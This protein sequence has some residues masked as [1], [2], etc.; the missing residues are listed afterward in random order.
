MLSAA[1]TFPSRCFATRVLFI[2]GAFFLR[3]VKGGRKNA[4][5]G[6]EEVYKH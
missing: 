1:V 4:I 3:G 6:G 2:A 5:N